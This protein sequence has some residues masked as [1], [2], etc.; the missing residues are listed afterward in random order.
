LAQIFFF[1]ISKKNNFQFC[2]ICGCKSGIAINLFPPLSIVAV[3]GSGIRDPGS[4][5]G[6]N[7][8]PVA[9]LKIP[10]PPQKK[11]KP[12]NTPSSPPLKEE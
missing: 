6:K 5:I 12:C 1:S 9:R 3:F 10:P 4:G 8:D 7:Q 11:G 2:E